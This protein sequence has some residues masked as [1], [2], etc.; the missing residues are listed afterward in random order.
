MPV[1]QRG[2]SEGWGGESWGEVVLELTLE[3]R[4]GFG[5]TEKIVKDAVNDLSKTQRWE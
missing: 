5:L 4:L 3:G 2:K 1:A